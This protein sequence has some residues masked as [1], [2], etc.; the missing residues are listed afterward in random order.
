MMMKNTLKRA[1]LAVSLLTAGCGKMTAALTTT[2]PLLML[3]VANGTALVN[4][5]ISEET[6]KMREVGLLQ[7]SIGLQFNGIK[8]WEGKYNSYLKTARGYAEMLK[9]GSTLYLDAMV[10]LRTILE[11]KRA[12]K[13]NPEGL[14][15]NLAMSNIYIE[16]AMEFIKTFRML[17][18]TITGVEPEEEPEP[19]ATPVQ[20]IP[21]E[22]G[23]VR[24]TVTIKNNTDK[25]IAFDGKVCFILHGYMPSENY[26]GHK[27]FHGICT[28]GNYVIPAGGSQTYS[29]I[30]R[31]EDTP[32]DGLGLPFA[33]NGHTGSRT[34]NNAYYI[35]NKGFFCENMSESITFHE[36]GSYTMVI[37]Q[38]TDMW[39]SSDDEG[40]KNMLNGKERTMMLWSLC[41]RM[42]ELN[43]K[44]RLLSMSLWYYRL[45]DVWNYATAGMLDKEVSTI[46][47]ESHRR[48]M[49]A[50]EV[51]AAMA[52]H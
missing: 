30:F 24:A 48:W 35:G 2:D 50:W 45:E 49:R 18:Y 27:S 46:A 19:V 17:K 39:Y 44:L 38:N 43:K 52:G 40:G 21:Y 12:V 33:G 25:D 16:T 6:N 10:T 20:S 23:C 29:V 9:A 3:A 14:A 4:N 28:G 26:T 11:I 32:T 31:K 41:D 42:D 5:Q 7:N 34:A 36:G 8:T 13:A 51:S 15:A 47:K 37:P 22:T 1:F